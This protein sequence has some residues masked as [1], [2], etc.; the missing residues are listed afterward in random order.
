MK[1]KILEA[2]LKSYQQLFTVYFRYWDQ[3]LIKQKFMGA[4]IESSGS[5]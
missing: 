4:D 3:P 1:K 2:V 5:G